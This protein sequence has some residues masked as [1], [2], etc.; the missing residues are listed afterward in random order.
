MSELPDVALFRTIRT[1]IV[2]I[3]TEFGADPGVCNSVDVYLQP[4]VGVTGIEYW[5]VRVTTVQSGKPMYSANALPDVLNEKSAEAI[6]RCE[7]YA[8]ARALGL[9]FKMLAA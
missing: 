3:L 6:A 7:A 4:A 1:R 8:A 5:L 2:E 9:K